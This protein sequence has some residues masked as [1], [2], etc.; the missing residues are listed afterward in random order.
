VNANAKEKFHFMSEETQT[1]SN[2]PTGVAPA[3]VVG[4]RRVSQPRPHNAVEAPDKAA[5]TPTTQLV[6]SLDPHAAAQAVATSPPKH[7]KFE[8]QQ[9]EHRPK[10]DPTHAQVSSPNRDM[11][12]HHQINQ[13]GGKGN[14]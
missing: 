5:A 6:E 3:R 8:E 2:V 4:G 12:K 1:S 9:K 11:V 13:P 10:H 14:H 7:N